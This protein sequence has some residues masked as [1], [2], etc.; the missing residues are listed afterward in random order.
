M[1]GREI[2]EKNR[3]ETVRKRERK[4]E[5]SGREDSGSVEINEGRERKKRQ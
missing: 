1:D 3:K 2:R 5:N 4:R